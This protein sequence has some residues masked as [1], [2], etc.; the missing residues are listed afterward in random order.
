MNESAIWRHASWLATALAV[1]VLLVFFSNA[2]PLILFG[3]GVRVVWDFAVR[4]IKARSAPS[5]S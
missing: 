2:W 3:L 5:N 1:I 4:Q